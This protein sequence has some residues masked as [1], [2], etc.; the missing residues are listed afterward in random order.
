MLAK[1]KAEPVAVWEAVATRWRF[2]VDVEQRGPAELVG[3]SEELD[4]L[5]TPSPVRAASGPRSW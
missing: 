4:L 3:R 5:P 1:G 2:G